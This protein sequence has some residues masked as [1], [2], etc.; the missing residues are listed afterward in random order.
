TDIASV[1]RCEK[2]FNA[3]PPRRSPHARPVLPTSILG[4]V[5]ASRPGVSRAA[6][7]HAPEPGQGRVG[8][9]FRGLAVVQLYYRRL[10]NMVTSAAVAVVS[11]RRFFGARRAPLQRKTVTIICNP[12]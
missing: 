3:S 8:E 7:Y 11:D 9:T 10:Q 4:S 6:G 12:Q 2:D 1:A 5:S